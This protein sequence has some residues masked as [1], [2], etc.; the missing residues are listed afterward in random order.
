MTEVPAAPDQGGA[1]PSPVTTGITSID[2]VLDLV[3]GLEARPVAEHAP[4]FEAAHE[5]L[6]RVL[7]H[8]PA[9]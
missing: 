3:A 4:V 8:P 2:S 9:S 6:R 7:D 5:E 1:A